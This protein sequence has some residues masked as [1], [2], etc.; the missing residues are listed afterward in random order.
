MKNALLLFSFFFISTL[1]LQAQTVG[2][3]LNDS[4]AYNGYTLIAPYYETTYLVD[5]CGYVVNTWQADQVPGA[6]TYL[7]ENG[8]LLRTGR[9]NGSFGGG[10]SGGRI[11]L[12]SWEGELLWRY[13]YAS[14]LFHQHHDVAMLP[15]GNILLIAWEFRSM[16]SAI[17]NGRDPSKVPSQG[18]WSERIVELEPVGTNQANIVWEWRLWDHLVQDF[19][20]TKPNYGVV[21]EHPELVDI[22]F[23]ALEGAGGVDWIHLNAI[24]YNAELDQIVVSSRNFHEFW[25]IDHSTTTEEAAG[26]TGGTSGKGGDILYRWGNPQSY[27]Q[28]I[29]TDRKLFG[30]HDVQW[31]PPGHPDE[32]KII[33]FNNGAARPEGDFSTIDMI[34]PPLES[35]G[36]YS[37]TFGVPYGPEDVFWNYTA[38]PPENFYSAKIS[39]VQRLPNGNT[40]ICEGGFGRVFEITPDKQIVWEYQNPVRGSTGPV[41]Q[42]IDITNLSLTLFRAYKYGTDYPAFEGKTLIPGDPIELNPIDPICTIYNVTSTNELHLL[43]GVRII[44]NP[45]QEFF[46]L[47]NETGTALRIEIFNGAG[48][49]MAQYTS[50]ESV[51]TKNIQHFPAGMYFIKVSN[52]SGTHFYNEKLIK[53]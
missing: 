13:D 37:K 41:E 32:G 10:G 20:S 24:N 47:E 23:E 14:A 5:N 29:A 49:L 6:S 39:G 27:Q 16:L 34:D 7:L 42:G 26:H 9:I 36:N 11:E 1:A 8:N 38:N 43:E 31:V 52:L 30:Q 4:L 35:D 45:V 25:V 18:I 12:F 22:N 19:D 46:R 2:L 28:G 21:S 40:L 33:L 48:G 17:N 50:M 51:I 44:G 53:F 3:L 15:N